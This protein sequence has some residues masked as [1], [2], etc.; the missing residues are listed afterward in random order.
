MAFGLSV[1]PTDG[2]IGLEYPVPL[3]KEEGLLPAVNVGLSSTSQVAGHL[4]TCQPPD[5]RD[6]QDA[7]SHDA[8]L[9]YSPD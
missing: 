6:T 9:A 5:K 2:C 7:G 4:E 3:F 8:L 1:Q